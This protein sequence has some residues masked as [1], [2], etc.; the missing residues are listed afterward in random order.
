MKAK[1]LITEPIHERG[2]EILSR[3]FEVRVAPDPSPPTIIREMKGVSAL[4]VRL[5]SIGREVIQASDCLRVIGRHGIGV[6]NIDV[7]AATERGIAVVNAPLSSVSSVAEHVVAA[8]GALAKQLLYLDSST[9]RG[10][11]AVRDE[12]RPID[13]KGKTLGVVGLGK[14]GSLVGK[15]ARAAFDM[16]VIAF[17]PYVGHKAACEL[18]FHMCSSIDD[19]LRDADV[20]SLHVPLTPETR[21]L[22]GAERLRI[23]KSTALLVN[24]SR[25][26]VVDERAL[27][28]ALRS[29]SIAGAALDVFQQEPPSTDNPLFKLENVLVSPHNAALSREAVVRTSVC[30]AR[31]VVDVLTSGQAEF[32]VNPEVLQQRQAK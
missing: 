29:G 18:G 13:L 2:V 6:D 30:V 1:V 32:V 12:Y 19:L 14:I 28:E 11:W 16:Q 15:K 17:D 10:N 5:A 21:G 20:V 31:G 3:Q 23:M 4:I 9:R 22:I 8:I 26:G 7:K 24:F 25:G 27:Y